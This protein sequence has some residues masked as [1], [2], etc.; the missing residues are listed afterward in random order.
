VSLLLWRRITQI[1]SKT[2]AKNAK[3]LLLVD[4]YNSKQCCLKATVTWFFKVVNVDLSEGFKM[5]HKK[6]NAEPQVL[7][8]NNDQAPEVFIFNKALGLGVLFNVLL[9]CFRTSKSQQGPGL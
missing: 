8:T 1:L 5:D 6:D 2:T 9:H 7:V 3:S 4:V